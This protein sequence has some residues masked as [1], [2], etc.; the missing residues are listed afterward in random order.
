MVPF[1]KRRIQLHAANSGDGTIKFPQVVIFL[2]ERKMG[3][4]RKSFLTQL[5]RGKGFLVEESFNQSVTHVVS[6]NNSG[7][8]ARTWLNSQLSEQSGVEKN[9]AKEEIHVLDISWYTE[10]MRV[11]CPVVIMDRHRL[12]VCPFLRVKLP[13]TIFKCE[14]QSELLFVFI[15]FYRRR[16]SNVDQN[17]Q[18]FQFPAMPAR[19]A[20]LLWAT[21]PGS[22]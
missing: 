11:G 9:S 4:S 21:T 7:D 3:A 18:N 16:P 2:L 8:E 14:D 22:R 5:G 17:L 6:E 20:P 12:Q 1:K 13:T 15:Y 19:D 10:S